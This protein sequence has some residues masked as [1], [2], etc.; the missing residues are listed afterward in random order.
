MTVPRV[1][2]II[3]LN[4]RKADM[5]VAVARSL[6]SLGDW[7]VVVVDNGSGD[8]S[9]DIIEGETSAT[10]LRLPENVGFA[11]GVNAGLRYVL[12]TGAQFVAF[13][14]NDALVHPSA[15]R[16]AQAALAP[17]PGIGLLGGR[18]DRPDGSSWYGGGSLHLVRGAVSAVPRRRAD[19]ERARDVTFV[20]L[21]FAI[22]RADVIRHVGL[23]AEEYFF[24][25][26]EW[27][28]SLRMRRAGYRLRYEPDVHCVH[29][30]DGSHN[31]LSPQFVYNGYRNKIL[32]QEKYLPRPAFLMWR[33]AFFIYALV[34]TSVR[35]AVSQS[36][37]APV[38]RTCAL[39]A[40]RDHAPGKPVRRQDLV[41][42]AARSGTEDVFRS[43]D[44][45][46]VDR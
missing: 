46:G 23:L 25:Q 40:L 26:E 4:W 42:F 33:T 31:N 3:I 16:H 29:G 5:T 34:G 28:Y 21:A 32:F 6:E 20:T 18:I 8:G 14:N 27:D 17:D 45:Q 39:E 36:V 37:A 7:E 13:V 12:S 19:V 35:A 11:R 43:V 30:G 41:D 9:A 2:A 15:F 22:T 1:G 24:G 10:V 38:M 44:E